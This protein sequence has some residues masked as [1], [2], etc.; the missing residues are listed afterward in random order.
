MFLLTICN[1]D[2]VNYLS[3]YNSMRSN[4]QEEKYK[5]GTLLM[6]SFILKLHLYE[7]L[8]VCEVSY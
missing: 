8:C 1:I 3:I 4:L 6:P 2:L 7:K 5:K